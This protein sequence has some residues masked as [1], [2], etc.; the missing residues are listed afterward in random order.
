MSLWTDVLCVDSR[1]SIVGYDTNRFMAPECEKIYYKDLMR[2]KM[3]PG[4][5]I[6]LGNMPEKVSAFHERLVATRW[7]YFA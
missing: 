5:G 3:L 7:I 4:R 2:K 1:Y 6:E